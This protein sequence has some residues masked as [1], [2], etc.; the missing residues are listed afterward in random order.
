MKFILISVIIFTYCQSLKAQSNK[1]FILTYHLTRSPDPTIF[2][3]VLQCF[4]NYSQHRSVMPNKYTVTGTN[5][6]PIYDSLKQIKGYKDTTTLNEETTK[7]LNKNSAQ[8]KQWPPSVIKDFNN[9]KL[10]FKFSSMFYIDTNYTETMLNDFNWK[11]IN[12]TKVILNK[13]CKKATTTWNGRNY[14]AWYCPQIP[15]S[16]GPYKFNGLPGIILE[17]FDDVKYVH[18]TCVAINTAIEVITKVFPRSI[19]SYEK[20]KSNAR[21]KLAKY[22]EYNRSLSEINNSCTTCDGAVRLPV[23]IE[24]TEQAWITNKF[25]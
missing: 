7:L 4:D 17:V 16:D 2:K 1:N 24:I 20:F 21:V 5:R 11:L 23:A 6:I 19:I 22:E 18:Y 10:Y 25:K 14:T 3:S 9:K 13:T 12:E 8:K 15:L